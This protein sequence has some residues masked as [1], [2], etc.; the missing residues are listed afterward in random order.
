MRLCVRATQRERERE[1]EIFVLKTQE[2]DA[3]QIIAFISRRSQKPNWNVVFSWRFLLKLGNIKNCGDIKNV[4]NVKKVEI[5]RR[6]QILLHI[7]GNTGFF[8][9]ATFATCH[10]CHFSLANSVTW[11]FWTI[12]LLWFFLSTLNTD[13]KQKIRKFSR[14][15]FL[16]FRRFEPRTARQE[17][18][19]LPLCYALPTPSVIKLATNIRLRNF[20]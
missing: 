1:R 12:C 8:P 14:Y 15:F 4:K 13:T 6:W 20:V 10:S 5:E 3:F 7:F 11:H 2:C 9:H 17:A 18:R 19:L 16:L